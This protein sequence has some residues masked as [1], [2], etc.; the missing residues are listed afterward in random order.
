MLTIQNLTFRIEG[1]ILIEEATARVPVGR[2]VGLVGRN[3]SGKTT[4]FSLIAGERD[5]ESGDIA[6]PSTWRIGRIAQ[7]APGGEQS[8][9]ETV[10][11]ADVERESLLAE[12]ETATDP[13]RIADIHLRLNDIG[14]HRAPS[15]AA[16]ILSGLGFSAE[17][18]ARPC[19]SFSGG[20]RM[21]VALASVLFT[22]PDLL[23][24]DEPTNYLDLEGVIWLEQFLRNFP[25]TLILIS[26]DR[27]LLNT[28]VD[29]ILHLEKMKLNFYSGGYDTFER[30]RRMKLELQS[31]MRTKQ[32]T[33]RRHIQ[34][35]I[36]RFRYKASKARQ[37]QSRIKALARMEPLAAVLD[38]RTVPFSFPDP[39]PASPPIITLENV[40]VGYGDKPILSYLNLRIDP[41]DRIALLG[42]NGNG[43]STFAKLLAGRL[44]P[45]SG[46]FF[47]GRKI[48]VGYFAQHQLD[49][50]DPSG[51]PLTHLG[52]LMPEA[53][54]EKIRA[55]LG[56]FGFDTEK[57]ET[58][59]G[60][61]SGGEKA[62]LMLALATFKAPN[63]LLLDEPTNHLDIDSREAL[64]HAINEYEGAVIIISHDR[65]IIE[66]CVDTLWLVD[67]GRITP[68]DG[69]LNDYSK[70]LLSARQ[71]A[72]PGANANGGA[73]ISKQGQRRD[74]AG[75]R[76]QLKPLR[77]AIEMAEGRIHAARANIETI[78]TALTMPGLY[79]REPDRATRLAKERANLSLAIA[80]AE[81]DWL[82]A[83]HAYDAAM[84][85]G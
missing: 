2:K 75:K 59:V 71:A 66:T 68:F 33:Q 52:K 9:L 61:L 24:L 30:T 53:F 4:L 18:Q 15:R 16:E 21:R 13:H 79:E 25:R 14:A 46:T 23:L 64:V 3:G 47:R 67:G 42:A 77:K 35:Y 19:S 20:W 39:S 85:D 82:E 58:P 27:D 55:R 11:E 83:S 62:R 38:E 70:M 81:H 8:L 57:V 56:G 28:C 31:A 54:E 37:A 12:A 63:L 45:M 40:S 17:E 60:Q 26:H 51:T 7:E 78:D 69:D 6:Y 5:P 1:R 72:R 80:Q 84:G 41:D 29:S 76:A 49:E 32:E 48:G 34:S 73:R 65:H 36:D 74:A 22:E 10:L 44:K 50:M 43:K